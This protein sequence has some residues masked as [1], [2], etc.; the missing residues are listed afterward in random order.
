MVTTTKTEFLSY[1]V[2]LFTWIHEPQNHYEAGH[3]T[4]QDAIQVDNRDDF[5]LIE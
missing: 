3:I 4:I 2:I 1:Q 5:V